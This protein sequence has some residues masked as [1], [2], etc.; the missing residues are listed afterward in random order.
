M[1]FFELI[2]RELGGYETISSKR[3]VTQIIL[4]RFAA[5]PADLPMVYAFSSTVN[6]AS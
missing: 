2:L 1:R 6:P 5:S 3:N 4:H